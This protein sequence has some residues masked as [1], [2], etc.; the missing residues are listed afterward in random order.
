MMIMPQENNLFLLANSNN[1]TGSNTGTI[2][3]ERSN[4][5]HQVRVKKPRMFK[6][7]LLNDNT[8]S[9]EFV[10]MILETIFNKT[11]AE[12]VQIMLK[13][14]NTGKSIAG[15][16]SKQVAEAKIDAVYQKAQEAN[17]P[18]KCELEPV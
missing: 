2:T 7:I 14:H 5:Q 10:V 3:R 1:N 15:I 18:L 8:T 16:Y 6:V 17:Y 9:M 11:P 4:T 12:A 13:V